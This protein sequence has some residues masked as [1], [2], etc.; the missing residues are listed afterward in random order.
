MKLVDCIGPVG[1]Q[2]AAGDEEAFV[3]DRGQ[4][5]PGR[6]RDNH[7]AMTH[8]QRARG[9]DQARV[10]ILCKGCEGALDFSGITNVDRAYHYPDRWRDRLQGAELTNPGGYGGITNDC[11]S[12]HGRSDLLQQFQP[13]HADAVFKRNETSGVAART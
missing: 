7:I 6:K 3:V 8:G 9:H 5:V 1:N 11:H 13:F 2:A 10:R 12:R 4:F